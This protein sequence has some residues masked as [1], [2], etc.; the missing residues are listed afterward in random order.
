MQSFNNTRLLTP[1]KEEE[2]IYPY[3]RVWRSI[4]IQSAGLMMVMGGL[5]VLRNFLGIEPPTTLRPVINIVL[6]LLPATL[7]LIF[8][9]LW[10][11]YALVP[12]RKLFTVFL[13][14]G[15]VANAIGLPLLEDFIQPTAWLS[16]QEATTRILGYAT[17]IGVI[18]EFLKYIVIRFIAWPDEYRVRVDSIAYG[19]ASAI[20]YATVVSLSYVANNPNAF[21]DIVSIRVFGITTAHIAGS[22]IVA[23]GLSATLFNNAL[24]FVLPLA[25]AFAS[26]FVGLMTALRT[27]FAN[28]PLAVGSFSAPRFLFGIVFSVGAYVGLMIAIFFLLDVAERRERAKLS[29]EEI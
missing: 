8:S 15:L 24:S 4:I 19:M 22:T 2:D 17:T 13:I 12:R 6:A 21:N 3:R 20:G 7:W 28:T 9:R 11:N 5:F 1:P 25:L 14:S 10:E 18:Q 29:G 26:G 27:S 16:L 23:Y